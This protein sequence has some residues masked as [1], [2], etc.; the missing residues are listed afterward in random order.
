M[1]G[2]LLPALFLYSLLPYFILFQLVVRFCHLAS[3]RTERNEEEGLSKNVLYWSQ[4]GGGR[5]GGIRRARGLNIGGKHILI[6]LRKLRKMGTERT[7]YSG[8]R[9]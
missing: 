9:R 4:Q 3:K 2:H 1:T 7:I 5:D 6:P 8:K